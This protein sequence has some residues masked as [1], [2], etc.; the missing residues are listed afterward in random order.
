[1]GGKA[2][3]VYVATEA[4]LTEARAA[5][6]RV[7]EARTARISWSRDLQEKLKARKQLDETS[8]PDIPGNSDL[9]SEMEDP[10]V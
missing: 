7:A 5:Q 8:N 10:D 6:T 9:F 2:F 4:G 1:M 3:G